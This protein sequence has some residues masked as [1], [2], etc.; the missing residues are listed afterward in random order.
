[1]VWCRIVWLL[2]CKHMQ[3]QRFVQLVQGWCRLLLSRPIDNISYMPSAQAGLLQMASAAVA[4]QLTEG[5][6]AAQIH[7]AYERVPV[8]I[9]TSSV[10]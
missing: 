8:R 6:F 10:C 5:V 2:P 7:L 4:E 1:M 9:A 3:P